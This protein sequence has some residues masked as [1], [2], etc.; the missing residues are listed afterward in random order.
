MTLSR[1]LPNTSKHMTWCVPFTPRCTKFPVSNTTAGS[2]ARLNEATDTFLRSR[3]SSLAASA[4]R[5][6][7]FCTFMVIGWSN[8]ASHASHAVEKLPQPSLAST[9]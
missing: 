5:F 3:S 9:R 4:Y 2:A 6:A 8:S 1:V 7:D